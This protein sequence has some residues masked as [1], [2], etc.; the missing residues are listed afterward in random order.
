MFTLADLRI[1][2]IAAPMA[3][4]TST[5]HLVVA[6]GHEGGLGFLA[7][8]YKTPDVLERQ[9]AAVRGDSRHPFG[10]NVFLPQ[11][12]PTDLAGVE[13]YRRALEP[14]A[15]ARGVTLPPTRVDDD[16]FAEKVDLLVGLR[17]PVVSFTFGLPSADVVARLHS[18]G[19]SVV[20]TVTSVDE[21]IQSESRGVDALC[22]QGPDAGGHRGTFNTS[23]KPES[24]PLPVLVAAV[25]DS[26]TLPIVAAGGIRSGEQI[27]ELLAGG[28]TAVQLGTAFLRTDE[29]GA[30]HAHKD[31]LADPRFTS[32]V[33]T[34]AFS[35]RA[36]RGLLNAFITEHDAGAPW[37][38][39]QVHHLTAVLRADAGRRGD[40]E[41]LALWAGTG[42]R[43]A[44]AEPAADVLT[45]LWQEACA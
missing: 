16:W 9:I 14:A 11:A 7:A 10:V 8:G 3:G 29:S 32:T 35:G 15:L 18:V 31:A 37:A 23:D 28:A 39:P 44:T 30:Q 34:R 40:P 1:P 38:Y 22:V 42:Y 6:V 19:T 41:G 20:A 27:A 13:R 12:P 17:V 36:A 5:P 43:S 26:V 4:G 21:A 2:V 45:R 25:L 33:I 24:I